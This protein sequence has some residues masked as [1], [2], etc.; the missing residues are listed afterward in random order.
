M[1]L[2]LFVGEARTMQIKSMWE[3]AYMQENLLHYSEMIF[4]RLTHSREKLQHPEFIPHITIQ[5][6][7][8]S[9]ALHA[10]NACTELNQY[11]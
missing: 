1:T 8:S 7:F 4:S 11:E 2:K 6:G 10:Q 9:T 3:I 5:N